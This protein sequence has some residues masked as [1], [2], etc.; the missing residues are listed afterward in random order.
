[1]FEPQEHFIELLGLSPHYVGRITVNRL[2][3]NYYVDLDIVHSE[4]GKI[5][6]HIESLWD[7]AN[8]EDALAF[9]VHR[10]KKFLDSKR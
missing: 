1:M 2:N 3:T 5:Y 8:P 4:S 6:Q 7:Q 10:F 9:A